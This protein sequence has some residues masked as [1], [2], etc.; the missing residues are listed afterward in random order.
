MST[1][2]KNQAIFFITGLLD[3]LNSL[4]LYWK[5]YGGLRSLLG[6]LYFYL[7]GIATFFIIRYG[8]C[9]WNWA[10]DTKQ[11]ISC[12]VGFSFAGYSLMLGMAGDKFIK[13]IKG[14]YDDGE[15][16]PLM[17]VAGAFTHFFIVQ[18]ITLLFSIFSAAFSSISD[19]YCRSIGVFLLCYSILMLIA[20]SLAALNFVSWYNDCDI[21]AEG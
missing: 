2:E 15:Q 10:A 6:S 8:N 16:S 12:T 5:T 17:E 3:A 20:T 18:C 11:I 13:I 14:Q 19:I 9:C 4:A 7:A 1:P 21:D